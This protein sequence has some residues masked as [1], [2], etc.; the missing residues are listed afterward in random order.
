MLKLKLLLKFINSWNH[1][2]WN[3]SRTWKYWNT[4]HV[5]D[6]GTWKYWK[7]IHVDDLGTWKSSKQQI[8]LFDDLWT[9][10]Y[11]GTHLFWWP[12]RKSIYGPYGPYISDRKSI[13]GTSI[14]KSS[15]PSRAFA[16]GN[17]KL[18]CWEHV[19]WKMDMTTLSIKTILA[20]PLDL[21]SQVDRTTDR[22]PAR[23][24]LSS[25]KME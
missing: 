7:T 8:N 3:S 25:S 4:N 2:C 23:P 21:P 10:R 19:P 17:K 18:Q 11:W 14:F 20:V 6:L 16:G 15:L 13:Y 5:D 22:Q 9:W 12:V 24:A 1:K